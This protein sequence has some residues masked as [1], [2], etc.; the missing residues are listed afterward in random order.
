MLGGRGGYES[1]F[2]SVSCVILCSVAG[3]QSLTTHE[4]SLVLIPENLKGLE[5]LLS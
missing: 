3:A 1:A 2:L 5:A 4:W